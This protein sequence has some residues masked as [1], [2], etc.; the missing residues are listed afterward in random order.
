V[1]IPVRASV[2]EWATRTRWCT[3]KETAA[4]GSSTRATATMAI[5]Q[6]LTPVQGTD[7]GAG[8]GDHVPVVGVAGQPLQPLVGG[9]VIADRMPPSGGAGGD[10]RPEPVVV[11]VAER[12]A[13]LLRPAA[14]DHRLAGPGVDHGDVELVAEGGGHL[15]EALDGDLECTIARL[16]PSLVGIRVELATTHSLVSGDTYGV[17]WY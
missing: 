9:R 7:R 4:I 15:A 10:D 5:D 2:R 11:G 8:G 6:P 16:E 1:P 13:D 3:R 12:R 14:V 17:A